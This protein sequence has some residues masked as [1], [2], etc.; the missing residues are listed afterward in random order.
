MRVLSRPRGDGA[1][2]GH[3]EGVM[4][5]MFWKAMNRAWWFVWEATENYWPVPAHWTLWW[6][7]GVWLHGKKVEALLDWEDEA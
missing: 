6:D 3:V 5:L 4:R 7:L 2:A 1:E